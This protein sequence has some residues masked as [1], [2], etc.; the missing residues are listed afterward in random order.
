MN[1]L[2]ETEQ[3][4]WKIDESDGAVMYAS[5]RSEYYVS[6]AWI[7]MLI[8]IEHCV[9]KEADYLYVR[10]ICV[11]GLY[12]TSVGGNCYPYI[13]GYRLGAF[14]SDVSKA[15]RFIEELALQGMGLVD[16]LVAKCYRGR[17]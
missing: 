15:R 13:F 1:S 4:N 2:S 11:G 8:L 5:T 3:I 12:V 9:G 16:A 10:G 17:K 6:K 14:G 7:W